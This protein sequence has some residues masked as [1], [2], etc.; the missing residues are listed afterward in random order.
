MTRARF[1]T[2]QRD[3]RRTNRSESA[4]QTATSAVANQN[5]IGS[6]HR[7]LGNQAARRLL[8]DRSGKQAKN[9]L[10]GPSPI[11][12]RDNG[13]KEAI[14][15]SGRAVSYLPYQVKAGDSLASIASRFD[16]DGSWRTLYDFKLNATRINDPRTIYPGEWIAIP[17]DLIGNLEAAR[18]HE[19]TTEAN[20]DEI[21]SP[22]RVVSDADDR[23]EKLRYPELRRV[24]ISVDP[25]PKTVL[26]VPVNR[27]NR[28]PATASS[29]VASKLREGD[30]DMVTAVYAASGRYARELTK[31]DIRNLPFTFFVTPSPSEAES[32]RRHAEIALDIY[33]E[34]HT[35]KTREELFERYG[36][37]PLRAT[38]EEQLSDPEQTLYFEF[39]D[40]S[41]NADLTTD[42][43]WEYTVN[44]VGTYIGNHVRGGDGVVP[45][46]FV[47]GYASPVGKEAYNTRLADRRA[48]TIQQSLLEALKSHPETAGISTYAVV[49]IGRGVDDSLI[50]Y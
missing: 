44:Q 45:H 2:K 42:H 4:D 24:E 1:G 49:A 17:H 38:S 11:E 34:H 13:S 48:T 47:E 30:E 39:D 21:M 22:E 18:R 36:P 7:A 40:V 14:E 20:W 19:A 5:S 27:G 29:I 32:R 6:L 37:S 10:T 8:A 35:Q 23:R 3:V 50:I 28:S 41:F 26:K 33:L 43:T 25:D 12:G 15:V 46:I 9:G 31:E 16:I